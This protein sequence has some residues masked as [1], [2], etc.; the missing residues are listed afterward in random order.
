[1]ARF[2]S[3]VSDID[4]TLN[5]NI[6]EASP[7]FDTEKRGFALYSALIFTCMHMFKGHSARKILR[8]ESEVDRQADE[9]YHVRLD[10]DGLRVLKDNSSISLVKTRNNFRD[11]PAIERALKD[12]G[13]NVKVKRVSKEERDDMLHGVEGPAL[14]IQDNPISTL[15]DILRHKDSEATIIPHHYNMALGKLACIISKRVHIGD[16]ND[17]EKM[18]SEPGQ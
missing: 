6:E 10:P 8:S 7:K 16:W 9:A 17:V 5:N 15:K 12:S 2:K 3:I 13:A 4:G 1:M 14:L 18:I 11:L